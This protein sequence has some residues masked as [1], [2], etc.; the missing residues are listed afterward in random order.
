MS[1]NETCSQVPVQ[2]VSTDQE[3]SC[4]N[5]ST[6]EHIRPE[7]T[8]NRSESVIQLNASGEATIIVMNKPNNNPNNIPENNKVAM[9]S[10]EARG[11]FNHEVDSVS[12]KEHFKKIQNKTSFVLFGIAL[13]FL[14]C[15]APRICVKIFYIY[16]DGKNAQKQYMDCSGINRLHAPASVLI[17]S[18]LQWV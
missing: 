16:S 8:P 2:N 13:I 17:M 4:R 15:N 6:M 14:F 5:N 11:N 1:K 3:P 12:K 7:V 18:K 9:R 10:P